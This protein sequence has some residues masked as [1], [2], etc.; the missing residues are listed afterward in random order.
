[1][2]ATAHD[3][4]TQGGMTVT[5]RSMHAQN[6]GAEILVRVILEDGEHREE[7]RLLLTMEQY[8]ELRPTRGVIS[9]E[10][11]DRM[12]EASVLCQAIHAGDHLLSYGANTVPQLTQKLVR[13]G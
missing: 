13:R 2:I 11:Y 4:Y 5:V 12:E 1:M 9:E 3:P 7:R 10:L 8:C 6:D